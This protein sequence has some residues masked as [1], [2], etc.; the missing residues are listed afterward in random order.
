MPI[1]TL[2]HFQFQNGAIEF[3]AYNEHGRLGLE[4]S[5]E[6][7]EDNI[8]EAAPVDEVESYLRE[9]RE[10]VENAIIAKLG[11][12][13]HLGTPL[14]STPYVGSIRVPFDQISIR[15]SHAN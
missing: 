1:L 15:Y 2:N 10:H 7:V 9:N 11:A 6:W 4:Y 8:G 3:V 5:Q 14:G 12:S 13:P